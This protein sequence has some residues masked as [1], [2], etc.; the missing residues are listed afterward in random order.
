MS[1][2]TAKMF[3]GKDKAPE[4]E[5]PE[6]VTES[7]KEKIRRQAGEQKEKEH[8]TEMG[9]LMQQVVD[10]RA[11]VQALQEELD[12]KGGCFQEYAKATERSARWSCRWRT[13]IRPRRAK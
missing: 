2:R 11:K 4:S 3:S 10:E 9:N 7:M 6:Q 1:P 13:W 5:Q 8:Q 12:M